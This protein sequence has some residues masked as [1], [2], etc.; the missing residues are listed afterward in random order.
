MNKTGNATRRVAKRQSTTKP[1]PR[2]AAKDLTTQYDPQGRSP[3]GAYAIFMGAFGVVTCAGLW[4]ATRSHRERRAPLQDS[5]NL[6]DLLLLGVATHRVSKLITKDW[7]T[8]PLRAPFTK[9]KG[10]EPAGE[11]KEEARGEG[12]QLA[13]G[14]LLTCPWCTGGWVAS[15]FTL[16]YAMKPRL[17]RMIASI[18]TVQTV[19][20]SLHLAYDAARKPPKS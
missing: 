9:L 6:G 8:A 13:T 3:L 2:A 1:S 20:D 12:L 15:L 11:T 14:Q 16:A 19:S 18:F 4:A 5:V 17:T 7:V 10:T